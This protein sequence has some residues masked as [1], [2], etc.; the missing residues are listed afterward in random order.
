MSYFQSPKRRSVRQNSGFYVAGTNKGSTCRI[1]QSHLIQP[2]AKRIT[3]KALLKQLTVPALFFKN[4]G[5]IGA[6][7]YVRS[8]VSF[9]STGT[10]SWK[11]DSNTHH[12]A[13]KSVQLGSEGWQRLGCI[14]EIIVSAKYTTIHDLTFTFSFETQSPISIYGVMIGA[15]AYEY[16]TMHNHDVYT[17]FKT[18]TSL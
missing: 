18:K 1:E 9:T 14:G 6:G 16:F 7:V 8:E 2:E 17:A 12:L 15:L 3:V 4:L 13:L 10:L 11:E 5:V